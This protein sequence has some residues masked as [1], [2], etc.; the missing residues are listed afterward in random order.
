MDSLL[1]YPI[2]V[3]LI[4]WWCWQ[5]WKNS[6]QTPIG[7]LSWRYFSIVLLIFLTFIIWPDACLIFLWHKSHTCTYD[8]SSCFY[9]TLSNENSPTLLPRPRLLKICLVRILSC[10]YIPN[11]LDKQ[12]SRLPSMTDYSPSTWGHDWVL[13]LE[14]PFLLFT[15]MSWDNLYVIGVCLSVSESL[16]ISNPTSTRLLF[17]WIDIWIA[18]V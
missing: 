12:E 4:W 18:R 2:L 6:S 10:T 13:E 15:G 7:A 3:G 17:C 8:D 9:S 16:W 1:A 11:E 5:N 14:S